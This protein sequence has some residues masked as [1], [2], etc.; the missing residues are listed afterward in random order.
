MFNLFKVVNWTRLLLCTLFPIY[1]LK[2]DNV[3][4]G[5]E[6]SGGGVGGRFGVGNVRVPYPI[7]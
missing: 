1:R 3:C 2:D 6:V 4:V 7:F 5:L